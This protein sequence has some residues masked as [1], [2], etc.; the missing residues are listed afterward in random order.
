MPADAE[1]RA[2][3]PRARAPRRSGRAG[4]AS[5][6][7]STSCSCSWIS[8]LSCVSE[9]RLLQAWCR[10]AARRDGCRPGPSPTR[11]SRCPPCSS[12]RRRAGGRSRSPAP[13]RRAG[14]RSGSQTRSDRRGEGAASD[15]RAREA[16]AGA[17]QPPRDGRRS[18]PRPSL[19]GA[20]SRVALS[21]KKSKSRMSSSCVL[22]RASVASQALYGNRPTSVS[23]RAGR[24]LAVANDA[25]SCRR[26]RSPS[27]NESSSSI[28]TARCVLW[29]AAAPGSVWLARDERTGLDVALK[30]VPREGK[31]APRAAR[32]A[33]AAARL[34][35]RAL[36]SRLRLRRRRRP[37][38]HRVRVRSR[39][40]AARRAPQRRRHRSLRRVEAAAQVLDGLAHAHARG[41][42]HRDVKPSNVL[43]EDTETVSVKL[44][45]FGLAQFDEADTLTAVGDV[46][47]TLA[48]IAPGASDRREASMASDVWAVGVMLW[49]ALASRHPFWG[50]PLPQVAA[51]IE[52]GAPPLGAERPDLSRKLLA[53]VEGALAIEPAKRPARGEL[54]ADPPR[55]TRRA[56]RTP[57][58]TARR[59][60]PAASSPAPR[61]R[62]LAIPA[63][64]V[65]L[66]A[67]ALSAGLA[68]LVTVVGGSLLP[69]WTPGLLALLA[70]AAALATW[71]VPRLGLAT[72]ALRTAVPARE[73][74]ERR[75]PPLR[76]RRDRATRARLARPSRGPR[77]RGRATP[78]TGRG[79]GARATRR[80]ARSRLAT[81][82]LHAGLAVPAAALVAGLRGHPLPLLGTTSEISAS[83]PPGTQELCRRRFGQRSGP[84]RNRDDGA[85]AR[86]HRRCPPVRPQPR[87][88][89]NRRA[90]C[91]RGR[92]DPVVGA[93]AAADVDRSRSLGP[94]RSSDARTLS[95]DSI[96]A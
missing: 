83:Q 36:R 48:Y 26:Q 42:V 14:R 61:P 24:S 94:M 20:S 60:R 96:A 57:A 56:P 71:R 54:A 34:A 31:R 5:A 49:E 64:P 17:G 73:R 50:V 80:P 27:R 92:P 37:R 35:A 30:I 76:R 21:S 89:C 25:E 62:K 69:F 87:P 4:G 91:R 67:R 7:A 38:L 55:G 81:P 84:S 88:R 13:R 12:C 23:S 29:A 75:G 46:P 90:L 1:L 10:Q 8:P 53:A 66:E 28:A 44:L 68:G 2:R 58:G 63:K 59:A 3:R 16:A 33:E 11:S 78:G 19:V 45:D 77:L 93:V 95:L 51:T 72:R 65:A 74:G 9:V 82:K 41:I 15:L 39:T 52:A 43:L 79:T 22:T 6:P 40:H 18:P 32:E 85:R 86:D 47:G 70:V